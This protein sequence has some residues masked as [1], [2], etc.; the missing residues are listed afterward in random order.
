ME[1]RGRGKEFS[2]D[3]PEVSCLPGE[4]NQVFLN[5][6]VNAA[7]AIGDTLGEDSTEKGTITVGAHCDGAWVEIFVRDTG[8]GISVLQA[9]IPAHQYLSKPCDAEAL[10][11]TVARACS[12]RNT[13]CRESQ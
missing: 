4:L 3:L 12:L 2:P 6:I 11:S 10:K 5:L 9:V 7:H 8:T 13:L 1:I